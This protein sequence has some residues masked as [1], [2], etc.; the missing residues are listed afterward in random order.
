MRQVTLAATQFTCSW[1]LSRNA[2]SAERIT[3][4]AATQGARPPKPGYEEKFYVSPG[5]TGFRVWDTAQGRIGLGICWN[6]WFTE[7]ARSMALLGAKVVLYPT[8]IG[9]EPTSPGYDSAPGTSAADLSSAIP[10]RSLCTA[11]WP[12]MDRS[13]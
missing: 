7:A 5:D 1:D 10:S 11:P 12:T 4:A 6:Q 9:S 8:A 3:R 2:A 13:G